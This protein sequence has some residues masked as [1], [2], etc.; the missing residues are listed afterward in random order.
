MSFPVLSTLYTLVIFTILAAALYRGSASQKIA[1]AFI[2]LVFGYQLHQYQNRRLFTAVKHGELIQAQHLL[3]WGARVNAR[4][5]HGETPLMFAAG[6]GH[7]EL[8]QA[9]ID[10]GADVN[11]QNGDGQIPLHYAAAQGKEEMIKKL[12]SLGAAIN[13]QDVAGYTPLHIA[14]EYNYPTLVKLLQTKGA[15]GSLKTTKGLT[16][17]ELP[18]KKNPADELPHDNQKSALPE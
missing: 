12:L 13:A 18:Q 16:P 4:N 2:A 10:K 7:V 17:S 15:N 5:P 6:L 9:L 8:A 14:Y 3:T 1:I 11:A